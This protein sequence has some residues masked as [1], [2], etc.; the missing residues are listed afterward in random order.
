MSLLFGLPGIERAR[1]SSAKLVDYLLNSEHPIGRAKA[2]FFNEL[3]FERANWTELHAALLLHAANSTIQLLPA[4][5][6]GQK[7]LARGTIHG[8]DA[9]GA[10]L[11]AV[12]I[13]SDPA[14]G[15]RFVTAYPLEPK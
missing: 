7:Y 8:P 2:R 13:C 3:G 1:I 12:W 9:K 4:G 15:P 11:L 14:V 5:R 6:F 10:L